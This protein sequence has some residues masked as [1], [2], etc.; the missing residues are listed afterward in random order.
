ML[1]GRHAREKIK[2]INLENNLVLEAAHPS[3]L[4]A[5]QGFIGCNHFLKANQYL[6]EQKL[7]K[8]NWDVN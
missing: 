8:I 4:S 5:H 3:P 6:E 2:L 7:S 1:W